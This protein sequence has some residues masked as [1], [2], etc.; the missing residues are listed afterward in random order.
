MMQSDYK[1]SVINTHKATGHLLATVAKKPQAKFGRSRY[2]VALPR[3][4]DDPS[5]F[6][7]R[8][9]WGDSMRG[10]PPYFLF[11]AALVSLLSLRNAVAQTTTSGALTGTVR[12]VSGAVIVASV[13]VIRDTAKGMDRFATT[14][15]N[16]E[17][18]FY[19]LLPSRYTLTVAHQGFRTVS[20]EVILSVGPAV[21]A[22][23][24]LEIAS[25]TASTTVTAQASRV[26]A[27]NGDSSTTLNRQ[28]I[29]DLP[30][31]GNDL[32]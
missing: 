2:H 28:Q 25:A 20:R 9:A 16:G 27:D 29:S 14:N 24:V 32:T 5:L 21:S 23:I 31:P 30:N 1:P 22:D 6:S 18:A 17:Y 26:Q 10:L 3:L 19:F 12:D 7:T 13:V 15:G 4:Y 8:I 11:F